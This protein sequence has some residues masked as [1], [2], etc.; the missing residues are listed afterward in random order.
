[1]DLVNKLAWVNEWLDEDGLFFMKVAATAIQGLADSYL[2]RLAKAM[3]GDRAA[4]Q[5]IHTKD[6]DRGSHGK[7]VS[8]VA[9]GTAVLG[10]VHGTWG[11]T[12]IL[13]LAKDLKAL[14]LNLTE[15]YTI[16]TQRSLAGLREAERILSIP[17]PPT[18]YEQGLAQARGQEPSGPS[19]SSCLQE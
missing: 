5:N 18:Q 4:T 14:S 1:M 9:G 10:E 17:M 13:V 6:V 15:D 11:V 19:L 8:G 7:G 3:V 2:Q 16:M 12:H